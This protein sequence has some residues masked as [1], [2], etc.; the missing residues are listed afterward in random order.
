MLTGVKTAAQKLKEMGIY[1]QLKMKTS[2]ITS[3]ENNSAFAE[4]PFV[5][6][7]KDDLIKTQD[8]ELLP[9]SANQDML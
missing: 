5:E 6:L 3:L 2:D 9:K 8:R 7:S 1:Q 4:D